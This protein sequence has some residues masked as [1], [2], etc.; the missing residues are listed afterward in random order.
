MKRMFE[1][2]KAVESEEHGDAGSKK[3]ET[4]FDG[5]VQFGLKLSG[6]GNKHDAALAEEGSAAALPLG[7][8]TNEEQQGIKRKRP[9]IGNV[10]DDDGD[11][12]RALLTTQKRQRREMSEL[13]RVSLRLKP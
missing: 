5:K 12:G 4:R 9:D 6:K 10:F 1:A 13:E 8:V 2:S 11:D 3:E 7:G